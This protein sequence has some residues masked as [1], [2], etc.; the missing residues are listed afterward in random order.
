MTNLLSKQI[1]LSFYIIRDTGQYNI[2]RCFK[3]L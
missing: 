3:T 1:I 2:R